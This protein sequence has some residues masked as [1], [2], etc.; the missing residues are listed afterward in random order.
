MEYW[1]K[2]PERRDQLVLFPTRLEDVIEPEH[3]VRLLDEVL[4]C[5]SWSVFEAEYDGKCGRPPIP[6][7]VLAAVT[8]YGLM[9]RIRSSR[10]LEESLQVRLDF[11][12]LAE[13]RTIDHTTLSEF[14]RKQGEALKNL[15]IQV[16]LV[17]RQMG[18]LPL[19]QLAYDGTR[20]RANNR[21]KA[22]RTPAELQELRKELTAQYEEQVKR[23]AAEDAR[24][25]VMLESNPARELPADLVSRQKRLAQVDAALAEL[26]RVEAMGETVPHRIPLID[27][28]S[29]VTPNK[30]GGFAPNYTPLA[31]VDCKHGLIVACDV[32][33]MTNEEHFLVP[34]IKQVQTDFGLPAPPPEMLG[35]GAM[36]IGANL[37][38]LQD[39]KVTLYSPATLL[40]AD[41]NPALRSDLTQPV[42]EADWDR[43]PITNVSAKQTQLSKDAFIYDAAQDC[44]WCPQGNPIVR[45]RK[46]TKKRRSGSKNATLYQADAK[47]CA[48]CPLRERCLRKNAKQRHIER[49]E[50]EPLFDQLKQRMST[51][52]AQAKYE[53]RRHV[54]E[55]PFAVIKHHFGARRFLLRGIERVRIEWRWLATAFNLTR[56]I[57][58]W[59]S[60]AGPDKAV[61]LQGCRG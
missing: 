60:R 34:Q 38:A 18:L 28:Q 45:K 40:T 4:G 9:T 15:F 49:S 32:I 30:D 7:R 61:A 21:R 54:A 17:A 39:M 56:L 48:A 42:A 53:R 23:L 47:F 50:H 19:E 41:Q 59:P 20:F 27:P 58:L 52:E 46:L 36:S 43:L 5:L 37:K 3:A 29:R 8:L 31:T 25:N 22:A 14:R 33:A 13:G 2:A 11:R 55:T 51:P 6:P 35:D 57:S 26:E 44:Y 10:A 16:G 12:W 1:S 24:E